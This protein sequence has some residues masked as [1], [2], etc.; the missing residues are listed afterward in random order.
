[1]KNT[2]IQSLKINNNNLKDFRNNLKKYYVTFG[3]DK[4]YVKPKNGQGFGIKLSDLSSISDLY[5]MM[6]GFGTPTI[7]PKVVLKKDIQEFMIETNQIFSSIGYF[8]NDTNYQII[9]SKDEFLKKHTPTWIGIDNP[10]YRE[11]FYLTL[12]KYSGYTM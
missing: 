12:G 2:K 11:F 4:L 1:M 3:E 6:N 10:I 7:I 9:E 8:K 5:E